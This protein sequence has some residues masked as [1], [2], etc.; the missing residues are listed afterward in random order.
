[1]TQDPDGVMLVVTDLR[2]SGH[3]TFDRLTFEIAGEGDV[4]WRILYDDDPRSQGSGHP[5]SIEGDAV[6]KITLIGIAYPGDAPAEPRQGPRRIRPT[7]T[8]VIV[9]IL[10]DVLYEGHHEFFVGL[11]DVRPYR[12]ARLDDPQRLVIDIETR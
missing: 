4:G 3:D 5:V 2:V 10:D 9:E 6:L 8:D 12:V 1:M 7:D 11:R